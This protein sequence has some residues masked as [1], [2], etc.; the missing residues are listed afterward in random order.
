MYAF[1]ERNLFFLIL[2]LSWKHNSL[3]IDCVQNHQQICF[4]IVRQIYSAD[5]ILKY[6]VK[7][8]SK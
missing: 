7:F 6:F 3:S 1:I 2:I 4:Q 5:N 8:S